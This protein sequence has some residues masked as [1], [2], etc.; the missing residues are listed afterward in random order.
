M[1]CDAR[2]ECF[3]ST[4]PPTYFLWDA[5]RYSQTI[6]GVGHTY[7]SD[8]NTQVSVG[9]TH[10]SVQ[11]NRAGFGHNYAS[12]RHTRQECFGSTPPP[13]YFLWDAIRY[14]QTIPG[15]RHTYASGRN[16]RVSV[17]HTHA[18]VQ[19][20]HAGVGH[21]YASVRHARQECFGSTLLPTYSSETRSGTPEPK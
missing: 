7:A 11:H 17:R 6:P 4:P 16:T 13:T 19:H 20:T 1:A 2:Q 3:G 15:V 5:I 9:H 12:V 10:A 21:S 14:S 8:R 18:S